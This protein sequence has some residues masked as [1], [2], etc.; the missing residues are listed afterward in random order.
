LL[1]ADSECRADQR[2][3]RDVSVKVS[4]RCCSGSTQ[5]SNISASKSAL[6]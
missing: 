3:Y 5:H 4:P 2:V 1:E 6:K